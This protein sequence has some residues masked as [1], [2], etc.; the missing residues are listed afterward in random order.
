MVTH[1]NEVAK[2]G[3]ELSFEE[4]N[5]LSTAYRNA[6]GPRRTTLRIISLTEAWESSSETHATAIREFRPKILKELQKFC[7]DV[8]KMLDERLIPNATSGMSKVFFYKMY[9]C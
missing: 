3:G 8:L 6:V 9:V 5:L 7:E 2:A 1:V 4:R